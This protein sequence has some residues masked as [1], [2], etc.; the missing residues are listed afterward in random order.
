[1]LDFEEAI[2]SH[3]NSI[4]ECVACK[5]RSANPGYQWMADLPSD[6]VST[7]NV[8]VD[9]AVVDYFGPIKI[10]IGRSEYKRYEVLFCCMATRSVF[11]EVAESSE[12]SAILWRHFLDFF[13]AVP[14]SDAR[15]NNHAIHKALVN[16]QIQWV[17]SPP[18]ASHQNGVV[19]RLV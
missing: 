16:K 9:A 18:L 17:F 3:E 13:L 11:L 12:T 4:K 6:R 1:M 15:L 10:K 19:E 8:P 2:C 14:T 5:F 7:G